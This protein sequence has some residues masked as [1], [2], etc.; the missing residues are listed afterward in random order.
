MVL[1]KNHS[2][3]KKITE[4]ISTRT[5]EGKLDEK[6]NIDFSTSKIEFSS[7]NIKE[8]V[9]DVF[10]EYKKDEK[11]ELKKVESINKNNN[12]HRIILKEIGVKDYFTKLTLNIVND[13]SLKIEIKL[14]NKF[15]QG[16]GFQDKLKFFNAKPQR[17]SLNRNNTESGILNNKYNQQNKESKEN[18]KSKTGKENSNNEKEVIKEEN[19]DENKIEEKE[20]KE[21]NKDKNKIED[22]E[23]EK[24]EENKNENKD[25]H[26]N[27]NENK[28]IKEENKKEKVE[29][30]GNEKNKIKKTIN[31]EQ[32]FQNDNSENKEKNENENSESNNIKE[33][34]T[35]EDI[36]K[37]LNSNQKDNFQEMAP[38]KE[39]LPNENEINSP[40]PNIED[41]QEEINRLKKMNEEKDAKMEEMRKQLKEKDDELSSKEIKNIKLE[42]QVANYSHLKQKLKKENEIKIKNHENINNKYLKTSNSKLY[43]EA[44]LRCLSQTEKLT[45]YFRNDDY[46]DKIINNNIALKNKKNFQLSPAYYDFINKLEKSGNKIDISETLI[47]IIEK[48][49]SSNSRGKTS[50]SKMFLIFILNQLHNEL[51]QPVNK[52][53]FN[54]NNGKNLDIYDKFNALNYSL[55]QFKKGCSIITDI[56]YGFRENILEC[57]NCKGNNDNNSHYYSNNYN[58]SSKNISYNYGTFNCLIFSLEKI[59]NYYGNNSISIYDCFKYGEEKIV[60]NGINKYYCNICN[61]SYECQ[62]TSKIYSSPLVFIM[63]FDRKKDKLY[64]VKLNYDE[65]ID[66]T[67]YILNKDNYII[68]QLYAMITYTVSDNDIKYFSICKN[69]NDGK[70]YRYY[71]D[72]VNSI[73]DIKNDID[74]NEIPYILFYQKS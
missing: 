34:K 17:N 35:E 15:K 57:L 55:E 63:I 18:N 59:K 30:K 3:N 21:E 46:K 56:F 47:N 12:Y 25:E 64:D 50:N 74:K 14:K 26:E 70:W 31:D 38:K 49:D 23:N 65:K 20:E 10:L 36:N 22:K 43:K 8:G 67:Q 6:N 28:E 40:K 61:G 71:E 4:S 24:I 39:N 54:D 66:A 62:Y 72:K 53:N 48:I 1:F 19:K 52:N 16:K 60:F 69:L 41:L 37:E 32:E 44:I 27:K 73:S 45:Q 13:I 51:K 33:C 42:E 68:Y 7:I 29:E 2:L 11:D 5:K 9:I 58:F